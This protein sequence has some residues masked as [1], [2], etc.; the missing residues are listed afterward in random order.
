MPSRS[1]E[2]NMAS[3]PETIGVRLDK[4]PDELR[5]L[6]RWILWSLKRKR[7]A[8]GTFKWT[9]IPE[10]PD[11]K[12]AAVNAPDTWCSFDRAS[13][14]LQ[15]GEHSGLG[16]VLP[17]GIVGIDLDD[18]Y[19]GGG[20]DAQARMLLAMFPT[21]AEI[22]PSG[23]GVK[24]LAAGAL[25][26]EMRHV[27]HNKGV[28]LYDGAT[29][30]RFFCI[31]GHV[32]EDTRHHVITGQRDRLFALQSMISEPKKEIE[33]EA[34]SPD[35]TSRALDF[36][37]NLA[38][39]RCEEYTDWLSA[40]MALHWC[41][42]SEEMFR[43]WCRWSEQ[44]DKYDPEDAR[45]KWRSFDF[46]RHER[47][48][49]IGWLERAAREDGY[50]P[51]RFCTGM[52]TGTAL[53]EKEIKREYLIEN[54]M[55]A[56]E[57]M[58][59]GGPSKSLKTTLAVDMAVSIST[60]IPF[61]G[62]FAIPEQKK[63]LIISGESGESTLQETL[64]SVS[65][66]KGISPNQL[67]DFHI[68]FRL[69]KLDNLDNVMDLIDEL[70]E[71]QIDIVF[72]DPLYRALRVGDKASNIYAMGEQL[73]L[74]AEKI[75]RAGITVALCHHFK[76]QGKTYAE[77]PELE[78]LSQSGVAEFGR[79]FLLVKRRLPYKMDGKHDI[80]FHWGGS[81]GH[82]GMKVVEA[83]TG[84]RKEGL[85]WQTTMRS[86]EEWKSIQEDL[87][88]ASDRDELV[89]EA[90]KYV[91]DHPGC[92]TTKLRAA[93]K[94]SRDKLDELVEELEI[95]GELIVQKGARNATILYMPEEAPEVEDDS[96]GAIKERIVD[97][98]RDNPGCKKRDVHKTLRKNSNLV[99]RLI[100]ELEAPGLIESRRGERNA[101]LLY[102][103]ED[104]A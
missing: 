7:R 69:P 64:Q 28:E 10:Q 48:I 99:Y 85:T 89:T 84:T 32:L 82:Q 72:I 90:L 29:T 15:E 58:I 20:F 75:H 57:P 9:K 65:E 13:A 98:V 81:A 47:V 16:L 54:F 61:L 44:S 35:K 50:D 97:H 51:D 91:E 21:Y 102:L 59:I 88:S 3:K 68:S 30:G 53:L 45:R 19:D 104:E 43:Q 34:R 95:D 14:A 40:G 96:D 71:N 22:S 36:L 38:D 77:A 8:D 4:I 5:A 12:W 46:T 87:H 11:G 74:I 1:T 27:A 94:I 70:R 103:P 42:P 83:Y 2:A 92:K 52:M 49:T 23:S 78:D 31:T 39:Y 86:P 63:I 56:N 62:E 100:D 73:E 60:G 26:R 25:N 33:R 6:D 24:M 101:V 37:W 66:A 41:D 17:E 55:T 18:C 93:L 79:Q 67:Q 80:W 76:K